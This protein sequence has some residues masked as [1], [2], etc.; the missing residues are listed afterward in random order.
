MTLLIFLAAVNPAAAAMAAAR[1]PRPP[2]M[3]AIAAFALAA[4][5]LLAAA[6]IADPL[7]DFLDIAPETFRIA[8]G[9]VM[10]TQGVLAVWSGR[11]PAELPAESS[12]PAWAAGL[13]PLGFPLLANPA[14]VIAAVNYG[15]DDGVAKAWLAALVPLALGA[16]ALAIGAGHRWRPATDGAA[17]ILGA[18]LVVVAVGL[19]VA[20]VRDI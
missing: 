7:L 1:G 2:A 14:S 10:A 20:G 11:T 13:F 17:R 4:A 9:I 15:A 6:A 3:A 8:A 5:L 19:I 12:G 16:A 18:L